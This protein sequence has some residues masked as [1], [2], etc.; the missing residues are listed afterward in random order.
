MKVIIDGEEYVPLSE[1]VDNSEVLTKVIKGLLLQ[2]VGTV[3]DDEVNEQMEGI[4][5]S[6]NDWGDGVPIEEVVKD[7]YDMLKN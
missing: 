1:V 5:V 2:C 6:V 3:K 4:H 7:I